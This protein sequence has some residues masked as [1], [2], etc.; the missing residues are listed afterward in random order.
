MC[1]C[2]FAC[3]CAVNGVELSSHVY[4]GFGFGILDEVGIVLGPEADAGLTLVLPG[5][6]LQNPPLPSTV[7]C[8]GA[9]FTVR[10]TGAMK[11]PLPSTVICAVARVAFS[12]AASTALW[13]APV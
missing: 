8:A 5:D 10:A 9:D 6:G 7:A 1:V 2:V 11:P 4:V 3:V 12:T 13:D